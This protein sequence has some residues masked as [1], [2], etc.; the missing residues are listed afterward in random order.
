MKFINRQKIIALLL[1]VFTVLPILLVANVFAA[2]G[3]TYY[4]HN[5]E[6]PLYGTTG[7]AIKDVSG[8]TAGQAFTILEENG[9]NLKVKL[10]NGTETT[11]AKQF[12][13]I[14]LPDV[15]PSIKYDIT[16][17]YGSVF[18]IRGADISGITG[19]SLYQHGTSKKTNPRL[20][21]DEFLV[22]ILFETAVK[23]ASTQ[24]KAL[25]EDYSL[26]VYE[27]Y[28]PTYAQD[29]VFAAYS[30]LVTADIRGNYPVSWFIASGKSNHQEGYAVDLGLA[31]VT[32]TSFTELSNPA[33]KIANLAVTNCAMVTP[34]HDLTADSAVYEYQSGMVI[35]DKTAWKSYTQTAAF[36][37]SADSQ[38]LQKYCADAGLTPF[39]AE[40]WHFNDVD[41]R[42]NLGDLSGVTGNWE[43]T[44]N[45]S[46]IEAAVSADSS[47]VSSDTLTIF[48]LDDALVYKMQHNGAAI[49]TTD[50]WL[51]L[52][53]NDYPAYCINPEK[54]GV[55]ERGGSY[56]V[57]LQDGGI[58][59]PK[60]YGIIL[61]GY[62]Y[63][64]VIELGM[65]N[66]WEAAFATK[67]ALKIYL[68]DKAGKRDIAGWQ[69]VNADN[70]YMYDKIM[71]IYNAGI[72]NTEIPSAPNV[73]V[74]ADGGNNM[75]EQVILDDTYL[76][77][78]YS[79]TS[80]S[81][82]K[83]YTVSIVGSKPAGTKI[84]D[85]NGAEKTTFNTDEKFKV[86]IL[87]SGVTSSGSITLEI[88]QV[89][90]YCTVLLPMIQRRIM[91]SRAFRSLSKA[92][93]RQIMRVKRQRLKQRQI[94]RVNPPPLRKKNR[95]YWR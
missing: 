36:A 44:A 33:Y 18:K 63:K 81:P 60:I 45:R 42:N 75:T 3:I 69:P 32:S 11:I 64:T 10:S 5:F 46:I 17:S 56:D 13:M 19:Q 54:P 67:F 84:T 23:L 57:S 25:S 12:C 34:V 90:R 62:P 41:A 28:R 40:W 72:Q 77:K 70:Q 79:V 38:R 26:I 4:E 1:T 7:C 16:N 52:N 91:R 95:D 68:E 14:N 88:T 94:L 35:Y 73:T 37:G 55:G 31:K 6:L 39:A 61:S 8:V 59:D 15:I 74:T 86:I 22:P 66:A 27:A 53:G 2:S 82:I 65:P 93:L 48:S 78:E 58:T 87:K 24:K 49:G 21:K 50:A 47:D 71:E 76:I 89:L 85:L 20:G 30:P 51:T 83:N 92:V 9:N 29:K 43:L 80:D